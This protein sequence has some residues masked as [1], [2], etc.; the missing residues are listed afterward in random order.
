MIY[1]ANQRGP[2]KMPGFHDPDSVDTTGVILRP[3]TWV[4][5]AVYG[6]RSE[7]DYDIVLPTV[8]KGLYHKV[9]NPGK[10]NGTTE[11]T[12][13][14]R[15]GD[16][17]FD[18]ETGQSDGLE[19]EAVAYN[20]MPIDE[21]ITQVDYSAT[22]GVTISSPSSTDIACQAVIDVIPTDALAR[23]ELSF[24]VTA[25]ITLSNGKIMDRTIEYLVA[26]R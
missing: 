7:D 24:Q 17:T 14:K 2:F 9:A 22:N 26:E 1:N 19:W 13:A 8:F 3:D 4:A 21:T 20:L 11:P 25:H 18:F 16:T 23:T 10:A 5:G 12:W 15:P 6:W